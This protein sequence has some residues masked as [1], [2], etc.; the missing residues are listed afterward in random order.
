MAALLLV[1]SVACALAQSADDRQYD[2]RVR[3]LAESF[4]CLVCQNQSLADSNAELAADLRDQIREQVRNGASDE[5]IRAYMVRRYGDFVLYQPPVKPVTWA[6][7]F[8][9]FMTLAAG[10]VV[11]VLSIRHSRNVRP[12]MLSPDERRHAETLLADR[13]EGAPR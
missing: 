4:R 1:V 11:L 8:G 9:P 10:A 3:H 12:R 2:A 6:L 13:K 7:W 5:Q